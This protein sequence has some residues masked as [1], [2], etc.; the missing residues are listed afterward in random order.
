MFG[1]RCPLL[2]REDGAG[3]SGG[4]GA[5]GEGGA[6]SA[7]AN[8]SAAA[9]AAAAE[10]TF[11]QAQVDDIVKDRVAKAQRAAQHQP[12]PP[13]QDDV[14]GGEKL[15]LRE[16]ERRLNESESRR[17]FD[18]RASKLGLADELADDLFALSQVQKPDDIGTWLEQK[19][20]I[21][22]SGAAKGSEAAGANAN[23]A[24]PAEKKP[25]A[26]AP[27]PPGQHDSFVD[28]GGLT[29]IY[30]MPADKARGMT[31]AQ[32][33]EIHE[34]NVRFANQG[35]GAPPPPRIGVQPKR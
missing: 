24:Q 30:R 19:S 5:G 3:A 6:G 27:A 29:D 7:P 10:R 25:P 32:A 35:N 8:A 31:P 1:A 15:T 22:G 23:A 21:F 20:K 12:T 9:A 14:A 13:R 16:L 33:R 4:A 28:T 34:R 26:A 2:S 11:T 18:R 17:A